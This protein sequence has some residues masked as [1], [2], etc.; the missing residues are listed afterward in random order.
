MIY[1][2]IEERFCAECRCNVGIEYTHLC[3]GRVIKRCLS[4]TCGK[5]REDVACF[6]HHIDDR[7]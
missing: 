2:H 6:F 5:D 1:A 3:D 4:R 7:Y